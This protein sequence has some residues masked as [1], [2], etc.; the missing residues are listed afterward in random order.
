MIP[1]TQPSPAK[2]YPGSADANSLL[3]FDMSVNDTSMYGNY[4]VGVPTI[5]EGSSAIDVIDVE[6]TVTPTITA[7]IEQEI[8][9]V[10]QGIVGDYLDAQGEILNGGSF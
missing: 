5:V 3:V 7:L 4:S 10:A 2:K 8:Q 9:H 1:G 6:F